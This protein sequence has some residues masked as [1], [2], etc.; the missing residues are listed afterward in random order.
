MGHPK[1]NFVRGNMSYKR[2]KKNKK[3]KNS[4]FMKVGV[5]IPL[6][7]DLIWNHITVN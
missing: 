3:I 2:S 6:S 1:K 4:Q 5:K 7:V